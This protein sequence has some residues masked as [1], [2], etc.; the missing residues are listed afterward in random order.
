MNVL[1]LMLGVA[2]AHMRSGENA[3]DVNLGNLLVAGPL[4]GAATRP[5]EQAK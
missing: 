1:L 4:L 2:G 5:G 3:N